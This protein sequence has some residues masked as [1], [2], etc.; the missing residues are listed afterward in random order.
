MINFSML[1]RKFI[2]G[3]GYL[4]LLVALSV[5]IIPETGFARVLAAFG[6]EDFIRSTGKPTTE[7]REFQVRN[8][9]AFEFTLHLFYVGIKKDFKGVVPSALIKLNGM[10][11]VTRDEFSRN[12]HYIRKPVTLSKDNTLSLNLRGKPGSGISIVITGY[13]NASQL[14]EYKQTVQPDGSNLFGPNLNYFWT[15]VDEPEFGSAWLSDPNLPGPSL[16]VD[17]PGKYKLELRIQGD[18]WWTD[19]IM[20][21]L[22][23]SNYNPYV[24]V[25]V[26]TRIVTGTGAQYSDY[27]IKVGPDT[28]T[29]PEPTQCGSST[30]SGFQ[31]LVLDRATLNKKV[32]ENHENPQSFNVPCGN[33]DM[34]SF[35]DLL[36]GSDL[37][38]V[39]S[40]NNA[41]PSDVCGNSSSCPLGTKLMEYGATSIFNWN[42]YLTLGID[43]SYSLIGIQ[44]LGQG[45]GIELNSLD[46]FAPELD[47]TIYSNISGYFA[48]DVNDKWTFVYPEFVEIETHAGTSDTINTIKVGGVSYV[49]ESLDSDPAESGGFQ[50][51]VLDRDTLAPSVGAANYGFG[52][53]MTFWTNAGPGADSLSES[54]QEEMFAFLVSLGQR[55]MIPLFGTAGN[56]KLVVVITSIGTPIDYKS[57]T[58]TG[59]A[60]DVISNYYGGSVGGF[61][62]LG[63]LSSTYSLVGMTN[64]DHTKL[65][66]FGA[67]DTVEASSD[68]VNLR[69]AMHKD[70]QGWYKPVA[71]NPGIEGNT[72]G[73]DLSILAEAL[74]PHTAW[75]LPD[76]TLPDSDSTKQEQIAA[77]EYISQNMGEGTTDIRS[78]YV[79]GNASNWVSYC[80]YSNVQYY[81]NIPADEQSKI[82]RDVYN[83]MWKQLCGA[84]GG[85]F[86]YLTKVNTF[87]DDLDIVL[88]NMQVTSDTSLG[89]AYDAVVPMV[90]P[91]NNENILYD[92]AIVMRGLL[93]MGGSIVTNADLKGM[94][95]TVNGALLIALGLSKD[96]SG[97]DYTSLDTA[98]SNLETDMNLLWK[99]LNPGKDR[100]IGIIKSDWAKLKYVGD[101]LDGDWSYDDIDRW[102]WV[103]QVTDTLLAYYFQSLIPAA[104]KIDYKAGQTDDYH[105]PSPKTFYYWGDYYDCTPYCGAPSTAYWVDKLPYYEPDPYIYNWFVLEDEINEKRSDG[106]GYVDFSRSTDLRDVLFGEGAW[107]GGQKLNLEPYVFYERWL[108]SAVYGEPET[109]DG[110]DAC[111]KY[112]GTGCFYSSECN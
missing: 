70:Q 86:N 21:N 11:I 89:P 63:E 32:I 105:Q 109:P 15:I 2:K 4:P 60:V 68:G 45:K 76:P 61:N 65:Y 47:S 52:T 31:V 79:A 95:G 17:R 10:P 7:V 59:L 16:G 92:A 54:E 55:A 56:L 49:S 33:T 93:T 3:I 58:F 22:T 69:V 80:A 18:S 82:S 28:Y 40:L 64:L 90:N 107:E 87:S 53:N 88:G 48:P 85:E 74:K 1:K 37:V 34:V 71:I 91:K 13:N 83:E 12:T 75:P 66:S 101:K 35:L 98:F 112:G 57:A 72:G 27:S 102:G 99:S 41:Y 96:E 46:H 108:P 78:R 6:P 106:C 30:N 50:V 24:P 5:L 23:G 29:A 67:N 62:K 84:S 38:I 44:G 14:F 100:L 104:W 73:P 43:F 103:N 81:D 26:Q 97:K 9:D 77:Y 20:V 111:W 25:P 94:M 8:P 110:T 51:L 19:P 36:D 39:S 42:Y